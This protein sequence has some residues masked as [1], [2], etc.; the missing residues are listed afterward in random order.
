[1]CKW[2]EITSV[3]TCDEF[4]NDPKKMC[5]EHKTKMEVDYRIKDVI[6]VIFIK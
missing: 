3:K 6:I 4:G 5:F 1:M 2:Q